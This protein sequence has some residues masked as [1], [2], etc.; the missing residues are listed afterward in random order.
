MLIPNFSINS[1]TKKILDSKYRTLLGDLI[2]IRGIQSLLQSGKAYKRLE[3]E[4]SS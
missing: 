2:I 4:T 1:N 3:P